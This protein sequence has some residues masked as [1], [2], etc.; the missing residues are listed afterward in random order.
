M[1]N[2]SVIRYN[3]SSKR[4]FRS[5]TVDSGHLVET[6]SVKVAIVYSVCF[7]K[8]PWKSSVRAMFCVF[9]SKEPI[10]WWMGEQTKLSTLGRYQSTWDQ[11]KS[12]AFRKSHYLTLPMSSAKFI[13]IYA[14]Q[15]RNMD[16]SYA[17]HPEKPRRT[18]ERYY[19]LQIMP[20][21]VL[22]NKYKYMLICILHKLRFILI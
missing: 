10:Y 20:S 21:I 3:G 1:V 22:S 17:H 18:F 9:S 5:L 7:A 13:L 19:V 12:N 2:D 4:N 6:N 15:S 8:S 16:T 14:P 11:K